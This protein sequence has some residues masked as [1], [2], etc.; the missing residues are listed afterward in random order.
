MSEKLKKF[1]FNKNNQDGLREAFELYAREGSEGS[2]TL[3]FKDATENDRQLLEAY[4][5]AANSTGPGRNSKKIVS[6]KDVA[7]KNGNFT[8]SFKPLGQ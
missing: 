6:I 5:T 1:I 3:H 4:V 2:V 8:V 7:I